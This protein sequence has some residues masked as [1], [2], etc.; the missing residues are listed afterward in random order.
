M[1]ERKNSE[2]YQESV[3]VFSDCEKYRYRLKRTW[4]ASLK[5]ITYLMLNPSTADEMVNDPTIARC[6]R[7]AFEYGYGEM[8]IVNL[9]PIRMTDSTL[10]HTV[11]DL[12]GDLN[13]ANIAILEA[14]ASSEITVCGWGSHH[15]AIE[16][17]KDV[18][19]LI[20]DAGHS[21]KLKALT[22]N[23]DGNPKHPLYI[24]YEKH[25]LPYAIT[26]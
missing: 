21:D 13:E 23:L 22:V 8:K 15:L 1:I 7:R 2:L 4:D 17:A 6:Q 9:F 10:L 24:A 19:K 12:Y 16:R 3:A 26:I 5:S 20:G 18:F 25:P 14:V 11:S